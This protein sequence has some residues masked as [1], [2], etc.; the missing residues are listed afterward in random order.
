MQLLISNLPVETSQA[1]VLSLLTQ[2]LGAPEP[3]EVRVEV[4]EGGRNALAFVRYP[5]DTPETLGRVLDDKISGL[6]YKG[7]DLDAAVT[8]N[9]KE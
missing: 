6:H 7:H 9:F 2:Q 8:H 3:L 4:G 5:N 1:E